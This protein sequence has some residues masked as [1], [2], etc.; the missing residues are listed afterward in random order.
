MAYSRKNAKKDSFR[1]RKKRRGRR[2]TVKAIRRIA[3]RQVFKLT[4]LKTSI[5]ELQAPPNVVNY[6]PLACW[7]PLDPP[8][9]STG[10]NVNYVRQAGLTVNR[11]W[12][13]P[14]TTNDY[15]NAGTTALP[16]II[17]TSILRTG[18]R[19]KFQIKG[20]TYSGNTP[21]YTAAN[22]TVNLNSLNSQLAACSVRISMVR[23]IKNLS[24]DTF[25][26]SYLPQIA[27]QTKFLDPWDKTAVQV[28][29]DRTVR[30]LFNSQCEKYVTFKSFGKKGKQRLHFVR[31]PTD[32]TFFANWLDNRNIYIVI[33]TEPWT[34]Y[35]DTL[36]YQFIPYINS[37][38]VTTYYK[39][40]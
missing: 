38:T 6:S 35:V 24:D 11:M 21:G 8:F 31:N 17:G 2:I 5:V 1:W 16:F 13:Q 22:P 37:C 19:V 25:E 27:D 3:K 28:L 26:G 29:H 32:G 39:D 9:S 12:G 33:R 34:F 30:I 15:L 36:R 10:T 18:Y 20:G 7:R 4:D 14:T 40:I 23:S